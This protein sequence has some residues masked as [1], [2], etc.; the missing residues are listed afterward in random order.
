MAEPVE[1]VIIDPEEQANEIADGIPVIYRNIHTVNEFRVYFT[2]LHSFISILLLF[3]NSSDQIIHPIL[4]EIKR[5]RNQIIRVLICGN[6]NN[7]FV[8]N[9][10]IR[11]V[12]E[13]MVKYK[14][15]STLARFIDQE[16][17]KQGNSIDVDRGITLYHKRTRILE[18]FHINDKVLCSC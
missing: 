9:M 4:K 3:F 16:C 12:S 10:Y 5:K 2:D 15:K 6:T 11:L 13:P 14:M 17:M 7:H 8:N 18:Q 1:V